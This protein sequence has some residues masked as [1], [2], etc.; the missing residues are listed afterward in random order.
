MDIYILYHTIQKNGHTVECPAAAV[1]IY[2]P[3]TAL[4]HMNHTECNLSDK[5]QAV[6]TRFKYLSSGVTCFE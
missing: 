6:A 2:R 1:F 4:S 5:V 3:L